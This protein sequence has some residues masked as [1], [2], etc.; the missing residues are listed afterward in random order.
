MAFE[1]HA[2]F[3]STETGLAHALDP[4]VFV[5]ANGVAGARGPQGITHSADLRNAW[6]D[7]T[8]DAPIFNA[9]AQPLSMTLG[10]WLG[11]RGTA[12]LTPLSNGCEQIIVSLTGLKPD[13]KY[14]LFENHF[15]RNPIRFTPLNGSGHS[16]S[17]RAD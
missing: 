10:Q 12:R 4:Q 13:G 2:A 14:S 17:F 11:A 8:A 5:R 16:N 9:N 6:V 1:T 7:D 15:D 3:F